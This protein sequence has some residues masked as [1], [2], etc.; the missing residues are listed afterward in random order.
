MAV[1]KLN[2]EQD[3]KRPRS[4]VK[5]PGYTMADSIAVADVIHKKGGGA[6]TI[7]ELAA[8]LGYGGTNNGAFLTRV[9]A[10]RTFGFID[11]SG[12]KFVLTQLAQSILMPVY[13]WMSKEA[14]VKAFLNVELF[15]K[16]Y[17]E[18]KGKQLP[19]EFGLKN[20]LK[21]M[22][23]VVPKSVERAYRVL[24]ESA[25]TAGFFETRNS[26]THLILPAIAKGKAQ[27]PPA[28]PNPPPPGFGG[29]D[30]G[31]TGS[32][33]GVVPEGKNQPPTSL[34]AV[35]ATYIQTLVDAHQEKAKKGELD[36]ALMSRI[37]KLLG[38]A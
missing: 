25:D 34:D 28:D 21:T 29:G 27:E 13:D 30:G 2:K 35:K 11:K 8:H 18:Y 16:V 19:P 24:M 36:D 23:K 22:F 4:E 26:R 5:F 15:R 10:A 3:S 17:E 38:M 6:C 7:D 1:T 20:A 33:S 32:G 12:D 31:G 14:L 9:G 37:E